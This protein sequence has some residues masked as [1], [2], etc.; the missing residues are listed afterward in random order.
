MGIHDLTVTIDQGNDR[1]NI[2][3]VVDILYEQNESSPNPFE[4]N[5]ETEEDNSESE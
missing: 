2:D 3:H 5:D 1:V 4:S